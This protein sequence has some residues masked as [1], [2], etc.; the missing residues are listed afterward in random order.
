L[1]L[2]PASG[3]I[4]AVS[5]ERAGWDDDVAVIGGGPGGSSGATAL[6]RA[7]RPVLVLER[8]L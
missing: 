3:K 1:R 7:D 6:A 4:S 2:Q 8:D 5:V